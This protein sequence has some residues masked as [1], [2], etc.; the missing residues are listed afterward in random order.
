MCGRRV[1]LR[2]T[3]I[4]KTDAKRVPAASAKAVFQRDVHIG[5]GLNHQHAGIGAEAR[6]IVRDADGVLAPNEIGD[7]VRAVPGIR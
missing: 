3:I 5:A 1:H 4:V 7:G 2:F 6:R